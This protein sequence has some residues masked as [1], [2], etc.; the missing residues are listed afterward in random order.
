M[1]E[2]LNKNEYYEI[3]YGL[4]YCYTMELFKFVES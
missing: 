4:S 3:Q 2:E 1:L